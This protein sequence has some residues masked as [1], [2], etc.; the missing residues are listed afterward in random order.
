MKRRNS[1]C[2]IEP[3]IFSPYVL[4]DKRGWFYEAFNSSLFVDGITFIQDNHS[5]SISK[6]TIRGLHLQRSP[7]DQSKFV[8][9]LRGKILDVV[10]DLRPSSESYLKVFSFELDSEDKNALFVPKGFAHGFI[11]LQDHTEV[12]YKVDQVYSKDHEVTIDFSDSILNIQWPHFENYIISEKDKIGINLEE[13]L[14]M[15]GYSK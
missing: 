10:V 2:I 11:T 13:A 7:Y 15:L 1:E 14:R 3:K 8:R 12:Y 5:Y 6:G 9:V 4:N